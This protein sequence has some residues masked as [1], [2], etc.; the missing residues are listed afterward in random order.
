MRSSPRLFLPSIL[1]L[2][3]V[4]G[5]APPPPPAPPPP[6][7]QVDEGAPA[8][9]VA[10]LADPALR[11]KAAARLVQMYEDQVTRRVP[12]EPL[13]AQIVPPLTARCAAGELN[14]VSTTRVVRLLADARDPRAEACY[15]K[16]LEG[17]R[18]DTPSTMERLGVVLPALGALKLPGTSDALADLFV[19]FRVSEIHGDDG[20][21]RRL[22][23]TMLRVADPAWE[24]RLLLQI[25]HT[26]ADRKDVAALRDAVFW[27]VTSAEIL[28]RIRSEKAVRPLLKVV[29]SSRK[30]DIASAALEALV[31]IGKPAV[32]PAIALLRGEDAEIVAYARNE[33]LADHAAAGRD[34]TEA[35]RKEADEAYLGA[36][37]TVL[38]ALGR[39]DAVP[40]MLDALKGHSSAL[41][42]ALIARE[43]PKLP[44]TPDSVKAFEAAYEKTPAS[45][46]IPPESNA[47]ASMIEAARGFFDAGMVPWI[48]R[49][50]LTVHGAAEDGEAIRRASLLTAIDLMK[51]D[52]VKLVKRL[53]G[54]RA[55]GFDDKLTSTLGEAYA[56]EQKTAEELLEECGD[57]VDCYLAAFPSSYPHFRGIKAAYM[58]GVH[59][60]PDVR[61]KIIDAL[62]AIRSPVIRFVGVQVIDHL[63]PGGDP[64]IAD[65]LQK[66][67]DAAEASRQPESLASSAIY[68]PLIARLR[69]RA[70]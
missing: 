15:V 25:G 13:L 58:L 36:A 50:A 32:A 62:P 43:L 24:L 66:L 20:L 18:P 45:L 9:W 27:Q 57:R 59:G 68:K 70:Q 7:P 37:A 19:R 60:G 49:T 51:P 46:E 22:H 48:I 28:G 8:T 40:P 42:H 38:G 33:A 2:L 63:S 39:G 53:A 16:V 41:S 54:V 61:Q 11:T 47:R 52:Q 56:K 55:T 35:M 1:A 44:A 10:R 21:Y 4:C 3:S 29:A 26:I 65:T 5:C 23:D 67:V 31:R 6:A 12:V 14:S 34:I 17:Y 30:S 69:A 64:A